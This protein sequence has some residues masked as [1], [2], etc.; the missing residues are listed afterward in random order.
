MNDMYSANINSLT[1]RNVSSDQSSD[2]S[3]IMIDLNSLTAVDNITVSLYNITVTDSQIPFVE[4]STVDSTE[5]IDKTIYLSNI[6]I[7]NMTINNKQNLI[8]FGKSY[9]IVPNTFLLDNIN[10]NNIEFVSGGNLIFFRQQIKEYVN[11]TNSV[12][13]NIIHG[14]IS[15]ESYNLFDIQ[16]KT[17]V[18]LINTHVYNIEGEESSFIHL[19]TGA[20][21]EIRN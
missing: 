15:M 12:F 19:Y 10:M 1:F 21:V 18:S 9:N 7:T 6:T 17:K 13:Y 4:I 11:I 5:Y 16:D 14:T 3:N 20:E 8:Y 2:F